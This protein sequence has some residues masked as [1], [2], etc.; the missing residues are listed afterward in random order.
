MWIKRVAFSET[1]LAGP[2]HNHRPLAASLTFADGV[3]CHPSAATVGRMPVMIKGKKY[4][5]N[6]MFQVLNGAEFV[7]P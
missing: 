7:K 6:S 1:I 5:A 4:R 2:Y 3:F